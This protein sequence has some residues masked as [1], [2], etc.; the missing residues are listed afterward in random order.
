MVG[1]KELLSKR[2]G[3]RCIKDSPSL[4]VPIMYDYLGTKPRVPI[5][6]SHKEIMYISVV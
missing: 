1:S 3:C 5:Y 6:E 4:D 2:N